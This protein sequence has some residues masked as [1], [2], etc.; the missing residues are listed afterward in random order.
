MALL[1][2]QQALPPNEKLAG[3]K[4]FGTRTPPPLGHPEMGSLEYI[5]TRRSRTASAAAKRFMQEEQ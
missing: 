2:I 1:E 3:Q 5:A 4:T